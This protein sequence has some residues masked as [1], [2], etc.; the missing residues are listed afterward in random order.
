M[1]NAWGMQFDQFSEIASSI[2]Y[3]ILLWCLVAVP[4]ALVLYA[5]AR[6]LTVSPKDA[7]NALLAM[8]PRAFDASTRFSEAVAA[9]RANI[10][11]SNVRILLDRKHASLSKS[12]RKFGATIDR[13]L[14]QIT[15]ASGS[16]TGSTLIDVLQAFRSD[17]E[18]ALDVT[19]FDDKFPDR[20]VELKSARTKLSVVGALLVAVVFVNFGLLYLFFDE[21]FGGQTVP[22]IGIQ[23]AIVLAVIFPFFE[24]AGGVGAEFAVEKTD[25]VAIRTIVFAA[26][27]VIIFAL[28][29]LE[30]FIF[31]QLFA[32]GFGNVEDFA[33]GGLLHISVAMGGPA[34]TFIEAIFGFVIARNWLR[35]SELGAIASIKSHIADQKRFINGLEARYDAIEEAAARAAGSIDE[36]KA[37]IEGRGEAELPV[38]SELSEQRAAFLEA[39]NSVNP[40]KW[41]ADTEPQLGDVDGI[42]RFAWF[43]PI[44]FLLLS[45]GFVFFFQQKLIEGELADHLLLSVALASLVPVAVLVAGGW[46]FERTSSA[47]DLDNNWK[48]VLSPRDAAFKVAG[49][50]LLTL[51]GVA[52]MWVCI[53]ADGIRGAPVG[54]LLIGFLLGISWVGSYIDLGLGGASYLGRVVWAALVWLLRALIYGLQ[55]LAIFILAIATGAVLLLLHIAAYPFAL[56][57]SLITKKPAFRGAPT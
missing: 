53:L 34:L 37:K 55:R 2:G 1:G 43:I 4:A 3:V 39:V 45:A 16:K 7:A 30:F 11:L 19:A 28:A 24:A 38:A 57:Y 46:I 9:A 47:V 21:F 56:I 31:Y 18:R 29:A 25:G 5:V 26:I 54:L 35:L 8:R 49:F 6:F 27:S 52:T 17:T 13:R 15:R 44:G 51:L 20:T 12:L 23:L 41:Q 48:D 10:G 50:A 40:R 14:Q 22:Y 33:R 32:G 36:F 42:A